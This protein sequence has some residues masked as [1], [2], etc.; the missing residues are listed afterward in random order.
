[1]NNPNE[2]ID[3]T[4][5]LYYEDWGGEKEAR[6]MAQQVAKM[7]AKMLELRLEKQKTSEIGKQI[8]SIKSTRI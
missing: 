1:M 2:K 5:E 8:M 6:I 3:L 7:V 4:F